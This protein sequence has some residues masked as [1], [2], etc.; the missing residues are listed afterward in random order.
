ML[1]GLTVHDRRI[2]VLDFDGTVCLG[3]GLIWSYAHGVLE[4][5]EGKVA[6]DL[7]A[8]L[9]AYLDGQADAGDYADG[10][11][12]L[13]DLA[14][15]YVPVSVLDQAYARS[16]H[17]LEDTDVEIHAPDGLAELLDD[18]TP[19]VHRVVVTNAPDTGLSTALHRLGLDGRI[20]EVVASAGKPAGSRDVL[21]RLLG[22]AAPAALMSVGDMW[23]NDI[24]PA[25]EI[26]AATAFVDRLGRD[27]RPAH[28]RARRIAQ[29]YP[30]IREWA[31]APAA[32]TAAH[33]PETV[34]SDS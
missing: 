13:A 23:R 6:Q 8:A 19:G 17:A 33:Q 18:L 16:R 5:V 15:P 4:H 34:A 29:L 27:P 11:D 1:Y 10:Y 14:R 3:D 2:L 25:L 20:D 22:G 24:A 21:A 28:V 9:H 30:A 26:G 12:A 7:S 31:A 32:F